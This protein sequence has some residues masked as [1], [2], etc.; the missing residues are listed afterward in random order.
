MRA[1]EG[2][3]AP[4]TKFTLHTPAV[5]KLILYVY[6]EN[7][8]DSA[9]PRREFIKYCKNIVKT[10]VEIADFIIFLHEK[11]FVNAEYL[12]N[13]ARLLPS[14]YQ[15]CWRRFE[16]IYAS[17]SEPLIFVRAL[18]ITPTE[19][20]YSLKNTFLPAASPATFAIAN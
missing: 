8:N 16:E 5:N 2:N 1:F 10:L 18:N 20:L 15:K 7:C 17:E 11:Q 13:K 3:F 4:E 6:E 19:K 14:G 12:G 9:S